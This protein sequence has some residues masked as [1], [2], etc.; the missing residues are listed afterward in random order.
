MTDTTSLLP[1]TFIER[2]NQLCPEDLYSAVLES[3]SRQRPTTLRVNT[4]KNSEAEFVK[5]ATDAGVVIQKVPAIPYAFILISPRLRD[6]SELPLYIE[7]RCYV[8]SLSS[9]IPP[10]VLEPQENEKILDIAAAPGSKTSQIAAIMNNTGTILANDSSH[11]RLYKFK[12]NMERLNVTNVQTKTGVGQTLWQ[13]YPNYFDRSL[14]D[15]PCSMEGRFN[16]A[17]PKTFDAW[18]TKKVKDLSH[19]QRFL[20]RSAF[21]CTKPGGTIVYSTCTLSPEENEGVVDWLLE[22]EEGKVS[23]ESITL[24]DVP[25]Q[26]GITNWSGKQFHESLKQTMRIYPSELYEGF[27]VAKMTKLSSP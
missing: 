25:S 6:F 4:I 19:L 26:P 12:A 5:E 21:G 3:F 11:I 15:V 9:M 24:P 13:E 18:S 8:Q 22:K 23:V 2:L 16:T 10:L 17:D 27:Y 1:P 20:L 7:G 14:V